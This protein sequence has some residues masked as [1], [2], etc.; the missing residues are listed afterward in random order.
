MRRTCPKCS[1]HLTLPDAALGKKARCC[2]CSTIFVVEAA[3]QASSNNTKAMPRWVVASLA[4]LA[5]LIVSGTVVWYVVRGSTES[6]ST[7]TSP[8]L[9]EAN[10][11]TPEVVAAKTETDRQPVDKVVPDA[12]TQ[13]AAAA[14][15]IETHPSQVNKTGE[16]SISAADPRQPPQ[17]V[18]EWASTPDELRNSDKSSPVI[19]IF[20][21]GGKGGV[22]RSPDDT[23][24]ILVVAVKIPWSRYPI[25]EKTAVELD[26]ERKAK[27]KD[28]PQRYYV[29]LM[30]RSLFSLRLGSPSGERLE[31]SAWGTV[32]LVNYG[33]SVE[34]WTRDNITMSGQDLEKSQDLAEYVLREGALWGVDAKASDTIL[35]GFVVPKDVDTERCWFQFLQDEPILLKGRWRK[36]DA[37]SAPQQVPIA[38]Y[39]YPKDQSKKLFLQSILFGKAL[40]IERRASQFNVLE[41][42]E[43]EPIQITEGR[44][45]DSDRVLLVFRMSHSGMPSV[46]GRGNC[47]L[48]ATDG[49]QYGI[50]SIT[51]TTEFPPQLDTLV[52]DP[53]M[54][55]WF[56]GGQVVEHGKAVNI[57][58]S[59]Y[60]PPPGSKYK[61]KGIEGAP[62]IEV[63]IP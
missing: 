31:S 25:R 63:R 41:R 60:C 11:A 22:L 26:K 39:V 3:P 12:P 42:I 10:S 57:V 54:T 30:E 37:L 29:T 50:T 46:K 6:P 45:S 23:H 59:F 16:S 61:L 13:A 36:D 38:E 9:A 62:M 4:A 44:R 33:G 52:V 40:P 58:L 35:F 17:L 1:H 51:K 7:H 55:S 56:Y 27:P 2:R 32:G 43:Y 47:F 21:G 49:K 8:A 48:V 19:A 53:A 18:V 28:K 5:I 15:G 34:S 20:G 14:D 24:F